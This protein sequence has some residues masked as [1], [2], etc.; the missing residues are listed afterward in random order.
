MSHNDRATKEFVS[1]ALWL[2]VFR[3]LGSASDE[4]KREGGGVVNNGENN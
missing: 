2:F 3:S 1:T 4:V